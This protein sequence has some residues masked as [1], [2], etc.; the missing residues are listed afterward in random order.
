MHFY[1]ADEA[2]SKA[3]PKVNA[4]FLMTKFISHA[5]QDR[6]RAVVPVVKLVNSGL[7]SLSQEID[8][9]LEGGT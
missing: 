5:A 9:F 7:H 3:I 4:A 2:K 1:T 8:R 6:V